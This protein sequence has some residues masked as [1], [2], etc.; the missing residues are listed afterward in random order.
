MSPSAADAE[1]GFTCV[2]S[3]HEYA[4]LVRIARQYGEN[5]SERITTLT[6]LDSNL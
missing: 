3:R 6:D 2:P 1:F 4:N 5:T